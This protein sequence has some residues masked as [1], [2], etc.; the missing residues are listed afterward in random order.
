MNKIALSCLRALVEALDS[1]NVAAYLLDESER[2]VLWN[3]SFMR[4]FPEHEAHMHPRE[5]YRENLRRFYEGRLQGDERAEIERYIEAGLERN[6]HQS[7]PFTFQHRGRSLRVAS[8]AL[9]GLGRI[10]LWRVQAEVVDAPPGAPLPTG[11]SGLLDEIPDGLMV[12][13]AELR[14]LW[15]NG[16]FVVMY[17]LLDR[18]AAVGR[19]F[20]DLYRDVWAVAPEGSA[21][22]GAGLAL[23]G[24][25][26]RWAGAPFELALPGERCVRVTE[27]RSPD[28]RRVFAHVDISAMKLQQRRLA[29][30]EQQARASQAL[31]AATLERMDQG[32]VMVSPQRI[33]EVCNRRAIELLGLPPELMASRPHFEQV[34]AWQWSQ[35]E[36]AS[37]PP[38]IQAFIRAG[39][40][41]D[42]PQRY[43]RRRPD[44]RVIEVHSVPIEGGGV[45]RTY[46]DITERKHQEERIRHVARHD[47]LTALVNRDVFLEHL[48]GAVDNPQRTTEGFAVHYLDLNRFKPINDRLGH[49]V[50]DQVLS[51]VAARLRAAARDGDIVARMGGDEFAILQFGAGRPEPAFGLARRVIDMLAAPMDIETERV[52][53]GAA[54]GVVL[55]TAP[56]ADADTLMRQADAAMYAAKAGGRDGVRIHGH[57]PPAEAGD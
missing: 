22:G 8:L 4:L 35:G 26:T 7:R 19:D 40:I 29:E 25:Q 15:V 27:Q 17:G 51:Q 45:L 46:S 41:L 11:E 39:G 30:A 28:G 54:V 20:A 12:A 31:L 36:F 33:V 37:T 1:L 6:R 43:D 2:A 48:A 49:A 23:L 50:G 3:R 34:L 18:A 55:C 52:Q 10:R 57:P 38:D 14:I 13:D 53:V 9:P 16:P 21:D 24:E 56:G 44:G 5:P 42:Q 47:G 32:V